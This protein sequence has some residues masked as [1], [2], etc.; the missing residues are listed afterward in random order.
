MIL[1]LFGHGGDEGASY[2]VVDP[3]VDG[4]SLVAA[5]LRR[6]ILCQLTLAS[7]LTDQTN[8]SISNDLKV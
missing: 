8:C 5:A 2:L 3:L 1:I 6:V 4:F 7:L